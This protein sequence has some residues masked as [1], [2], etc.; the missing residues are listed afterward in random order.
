MLEFLI[1]VLAGMV[2]MLA[3][4]HTAFKRALKEIEQ[5]EAEEEQQSI[6]QPRVMLAKVEKHSGIFYLFEHNNNQFMVQ[7]TSIEELDQR[8]TLR[9]GKDIEVKVVAGENCDRDELRHMVL[10]S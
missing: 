7:G 3:V 5:R 4:V 6:Q 1:G 9:Y 8:L 2:L 10:R